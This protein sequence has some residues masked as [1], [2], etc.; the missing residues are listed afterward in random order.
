MLFDDPEWEHEYPS[1]HLGE[2]PFRDAST[3]LLFGEN[4]QLI[5]EKR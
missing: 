2:S 1:S 5:R 4:S 3:R